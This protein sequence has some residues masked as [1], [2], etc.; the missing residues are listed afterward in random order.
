[1][2]ELKKWDNDV[3]QYDVTEA[4]RIMNPWLRNY[5]RDRLTFNPETP[6]TSSAYLY[7]NEAS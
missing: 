1:M 6:Y 5:G 7:R 4:S 2:S 3:Y